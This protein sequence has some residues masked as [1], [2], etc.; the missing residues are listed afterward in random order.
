M[1]ADCGKIFYDEPGASE[2]VQRNVCAHADGFGQRIM[3]CTQC[4]FKLNTEEAL[5][6][7]YHAET[8]QR[9]VSYDACQ[10]VEGGEGHIMGVVTAQQ[11]VC[12]SCSAV[13]AEEAKF[14]PAEG[15]TVEPHTFENGVCTECG[16]K[17]EVGPEPSDE[18]I[19]P[20][21]T[22]VPTQPVPSDEPI[23][24]TAT[25]V[26]TQPVPSDEPIS[27]TVTPVPTQPVPSDEPI[28]PTATPAPTQSVP[29]D[30]PIEPTSTPAPV[31]TQVPATETVLA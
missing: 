13:V 12:K 3:Q 10:P 22:P 31:Y 29:I 11:T 9:Q 7:S 14:M 16:Y 6:D 28:S 27:P 26:P 24:P 20:T 17:Q 30:V 21:A 8:Y 23:S 19:S 5:Y 25:P 18:P 1:C 4:E 2:P 15:A